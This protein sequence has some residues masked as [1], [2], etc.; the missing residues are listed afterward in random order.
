MTADRP[1]EIPIDG[2][3]DLHAFNP[4]EVKDLVQEYLE[5][6]ARRGIAHVRLIHGKGTGTLKCIVHGLLKKNPGV[7]H[8]RDADLGGGSWGATEVFLKCPM[9]PPPGRGKR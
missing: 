5:E 9:L 1:L 2:V 4:R 3:L 7:L 6:C 8:F